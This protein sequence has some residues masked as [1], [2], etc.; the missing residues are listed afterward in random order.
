M[1]AEVVQEFFLVGV[2]LTAVVAA[3]EP[4]ADVW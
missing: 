3:G 2:P 4:R 1:G